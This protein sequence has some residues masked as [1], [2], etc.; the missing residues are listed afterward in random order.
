LGSV[1]S[2]E[3]DLTATMLLR[4][5]L[6]A[7]GLLVSGA[8]AQSKDSVDALAQQFFGGASPSVPSGSATGGHSGGHTN[9]WAVLVCTSR[10]WFNYRHIANTLS[11][12][13]TVKRL[14]IPDSR[15][16]V[17][18]CTSILIL[19]KVDVGGRCGV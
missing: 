7:L 4:R 17:P 10:F 13:R 18:S 15:I 5:F 19:I 1:V 2:F 3:F 6:L 12:Y 14:G 16:I 11:L 9:N 8:M